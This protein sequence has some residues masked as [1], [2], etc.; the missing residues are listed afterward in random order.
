MSNPMVAY[1]K[2]L[3]ADIELLQKRAVRGEA[4]RAADVTALLARYGTSFGLLPRY[5]QTAIDRI[6]LADGLSVLTCPEDS[7]TPTTPTTERTHAHGNA[8]CR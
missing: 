4:V 5:L 1:E 2:A 7:R 8:S 6:D 3:L